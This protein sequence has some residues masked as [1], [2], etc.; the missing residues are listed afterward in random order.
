MFLNRALVALFAA[1][2][3]A[4]AANPVADPQPDDAHLPDIRLSPLEVRALKEAQKYPPGYVH[5]IVTL[6]TGENAKEVPIVEADPDML[7]DDEKGIKARSLAP[8]G[9]CFSF[10]AASSGCMIDYCWKDN[11]GNTWSR[12]IIIRGSNGQ[13]NP[14]AVTSSDTNRLSF[15]S[16]YN[17]GYNGWFPEGHECSNS[18]TQIYTDHRLSTG[19]LGTAY[20]NRVRCDNCNFGFLRCL[21]DSLKNNLI[22]Y[23]NGVGS[24]S[25]CT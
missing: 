14:S 20:V 23:S 3:I 19:I 10:P 24:Q 13:S 17:D 22:A 7:L 8:R 15:N 5:K 9:T 18:D 11:D 16:I 21:S 1:W 2:T 4:A 6:G 25:Y 12:F